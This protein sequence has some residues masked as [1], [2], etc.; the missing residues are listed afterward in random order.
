MS[1]LFPHW[2]QVGSILGGNG[3]GWWH[4]GR[5][6]GTTFV[7]EITGLLDIGSI[8]A[9]QWYVDEGGR[10]L[11]MAWVYDFDTYKYPSRVK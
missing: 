2:R 8:Y 3:Q 4:V 5:Y 6:D 1:Q 11:L 9:A 10:N 7:S